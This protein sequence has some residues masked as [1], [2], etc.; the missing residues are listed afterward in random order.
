MSTFLRGRYLLLDTF[1]YSR[2]AQYFADRS[3]EEGFQAHQPLLVCDL[4]AVPRDLFMDHE[5]PD[6]YPMSVSSWSLV[7]MQCRLYAWH[8]DC[9]PSSARS[10]RSSPYNIHSLTLCIPTF[11]EHQTTAYYWHT[12][13]ET[14]TFLPSWYSYSASRIMDAQRRVAGED[15]A[16]AV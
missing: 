3:I 8:V 1:V 15:F 4:A 7:S 14:N 6:G 16:R 10:R 13:A 12:V 9:D 11:L 5:Q 2:T